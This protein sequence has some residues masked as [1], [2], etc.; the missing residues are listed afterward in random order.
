MG[1][2]YHVRHEHEPEMKRIP[3]GGQM[4]VHGASPEPMVF[5]GAKAKKSMLQHVN[6]LSDQ[7][8]AGLGTGNGDGGGQGGNIAGSAQPSPTTGGI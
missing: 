6:N 2:G 7:M 5:S 1:N 4:A 3:G 8:G